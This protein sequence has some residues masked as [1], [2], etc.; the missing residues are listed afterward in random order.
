MNRLFPVAAFLFVVL[1]AAVLCGASPVQSHKAGIAKHYRPNLMEQV[2]KNRMNPRH[3]GY[4]PG[5]RMRYDVA[6]YASRPDCS[7]IGRVFWASVSG[8]QFRLYQQV[9]CSHPRDRQRHLSTG[10]IAELDYKSAVREGFARDG[11]A[12]AKVRYP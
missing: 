5:F 7:T 6:G 2:A 12:P 9:D 3:A 1:G 8:Q 10:L 11:K 4:V